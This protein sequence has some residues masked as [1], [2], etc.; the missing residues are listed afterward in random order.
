VK[1]ESDDLSIAVT[2]DRCRTNVSIEHSV[3]TLGFYVSNCPTR[4]DYLQFI[5]FLQTALHVSDGYSTHH[6]EQITVI[7]ASGTG[8][9]VAATFRYRDKVPLLSR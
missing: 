2:E 7:T 4:C 5:I 6:Q 3:N 8:Q 9:A 1:T